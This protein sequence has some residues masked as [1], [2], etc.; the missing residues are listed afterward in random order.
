MWMLA[1]C[2]QVIR[3]WS[4]SLDRHIPWWRKLLIGMH[5]RRCPPCARY[6]E[7]V[8]VTRNLHKHAALATS[9]Q[10]SDARKAR[11]VYAMENS[12]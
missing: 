2:K 7:Q 3:W 8:T 4:E 6:Q 12:E 10:L 1:S 5:T 11:I 9:E